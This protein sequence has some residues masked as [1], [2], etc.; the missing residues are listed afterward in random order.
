M[1]TELL[2]EIIHEKEAITS[3][4]HIQNY[5]IMV[6]GIC[7]VLPCRLSKSIFEVYCRDGSEPRLELEVRA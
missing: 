5:Y 3:F 7:N 6:E 1:R 2:A 4:F